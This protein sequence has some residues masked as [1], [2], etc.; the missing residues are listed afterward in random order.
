LT[1]VSLGKE[2]E[3]KAV[4][5]LESIGHTILKKNFRKRNGEIDI[6]SR[7]ENTLYFIEV[8]TWRSALSHPLESLTK[9]KCDRM[10]GMASLFLYELGWIESNFTISFSLLYVQ[11]EK[12]D[13]YTELF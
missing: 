12:I 4:L 9:I 5:Y 2:G 8:K 7:L 1:K 11:E 10:R 13:F 6:I 3:R